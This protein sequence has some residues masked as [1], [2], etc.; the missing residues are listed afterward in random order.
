MAYIAE[1]M[2]EM[3]YYFGYAKV[4][5]EPANLTGFFNYSE[6]DPELIRNYKAFEAHR[7]QTIDWVCSLNDDE[8]N[9]FQ[10]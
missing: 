7:A 9:S 6:E 8:L 4:K 3:I 1:E 2:K 5:R 10:Y